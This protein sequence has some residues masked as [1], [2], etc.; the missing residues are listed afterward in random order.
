[1]KGKLNNPAKVDAISPIGF[2]THESNSFLGL[3]T[4]QDSSI[5]QKPHLPSP[6][7]HDLLLKYGNTFSGFCRLGRGMHALIA[8]FTKT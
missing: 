1:M 8:V 6:N 7:K 3:G 5:V 4:G 2:S